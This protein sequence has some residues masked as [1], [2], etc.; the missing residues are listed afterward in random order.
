MEL[1]ALGEFH[2][3]PTPLFLRRFHA[4]SSTG[5]AAAW[6]TP[7]KPG[8][9]RFPVSR[10]TMRTT[11]ALATSDHPAARRMSICAAFLAVWGY[12]EARVT[13][14]RWKAKLRERLG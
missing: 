10:L 11:R 4:N 6:Y 9:E 14:G 13:G 1:A 7:T 2:E 8:A 12:R 3:V 5:Q